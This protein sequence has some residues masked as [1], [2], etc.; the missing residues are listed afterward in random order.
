MKK[1]TLTKAAAI[2]CMALITALPAKAAE[3]TTGG[4][5]NSPAA[6]AFYLKGKVLDDTGEPLTGA[7][8]KIK[9]TDTGV[10]TDLNGN[11][12]IPVTKQGRYTLNITFVGMTALETAAT[13]TKAI[14]VK[15][16]ADSKV[17]D[18]V[19]VSGFQT[20]SRERN[21]GS[22][23][24]VNSEKLSKIQATTLS[25][26]LEG[27]TPGLTIYNGDMS[28]RG[29]SS[30]AVS[31][32][33]LLVIDGQPATGI[34]IDN[35]NP[36]IIDQ[37]TVLKDA[38]ATSLYGVRASNGVIV[39]TTKNA[40]KDKL[41]IN[42]S[43][44]YYLKPLPSLS[45]KHYASTSDI[46]D[47]EEEFLLSDPDYQ[48]NPLAYFNTLTNKSNATFMTQVDMIYYRL[49]K[50]EIDQAGA[51]SA[52]DALRNYDY[53]KLQRVGVKGRR[54]IQLLRLWTTQEQRHVHKVQRQQ[55]ST[56]IPQKRPAGGTM[57]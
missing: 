34:S 21:T 35:I 47:L 6:T 25:S 8:V 52:I 56:A 22:A 13:T 5:M 46:I 37:V 51:K 1:T 2:T 40:A 32:T 48:A 15:M 28:I 57:V 16:E 7:V 23:V 45:Y 27:M 20:I 49:A 42:V 11:F 10:L 33:P 43:A 12:S 26:K 50:G 24:I 9:G 14:V 18:E 44:N 30:F 54:Q 19:V 31:G 38:A 4:S 53:R 17:L 36:E 41:D 39:I 3:D 55:Y 29:T